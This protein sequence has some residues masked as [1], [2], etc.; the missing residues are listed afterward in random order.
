MRS[1]DG[2]WGAFDVDN[3][4]ALV[5]D[6]PFCDFGEVI[7]PPSAD[8]TAHVVEML[9]VLGRGDDELT[10]GGVSWLLNNQEQDGSG[11]GAGRHHVYGTGAVPAAWSP[12][13]CRWPIRRYAAR[14]RWLERHRTQTAV[15]V[16]TAAPTTIR[17]WN[18]FAAR[19]TPSQTAWALLALE[20]AGEADSAAARGECSGCSSIS[21]KT[22]TGNEDHHTGTGFPSDFYI[23]YHLY[24]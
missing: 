8:V 11:S 19:S 12:P 23:K 9:G 24:A 20:A 3:C 6:V 15:G 14:V 2:G 4:R 16:R 10:W 17:P 7:D 1:S 13:A 22:A 18:R 5:R 21:A